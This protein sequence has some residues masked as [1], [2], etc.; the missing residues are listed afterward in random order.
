MVSYRARR[1]SLGTSVAL[2]AVIALLSASVAHAAKPQ[3]FVFSPDEGFVA[4]AG[5]ICAFPLQIDPLPG[6][7]QVVMVFSDGREVTLGHGGPIMTNLETGESRSEKARFEAITTFD[8]AANT[9][10]FDVSGRIVWFLA[11]GDQGPFGQIDGT[12]GLFLIAGRSQATFDLAT[13]AVT[14]FAWNGVYTDL[15]D[16]LDG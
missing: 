2:A 7:R 10:T 6:A 14:A 16:A 1:T 15:C 9:L 13:G 5:T 4:A 8:A 11:L 3:R 12:D